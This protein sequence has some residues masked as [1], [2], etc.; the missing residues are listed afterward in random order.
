MSKRRNHDAAFKA[1]L[2]LEAVK[3]EHGFVTG[4]GIW[5]ASDDDPSLKALTSGGCGGHLRTRWQGLCGGR[6]WR[7]NGS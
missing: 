7:R 4:Y 2:A 3:R 5:R 6:G 1:R